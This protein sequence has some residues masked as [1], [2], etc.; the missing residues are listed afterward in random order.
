MFDEEI[1]PV[2]VSQIILGD[3]LE[4]LSI[5]DLEDRLEALRTEIARVESELSSKRRGRE[6]AEAVFGKA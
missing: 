3:N 6:E 4:R 5:G 1:G 2:P